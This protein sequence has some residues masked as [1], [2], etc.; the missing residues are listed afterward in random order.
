MFNIHQNYL[1]EIKS[2][3]GYIDKKYV[4]DYFNGLHPSQ[5]MHILNCKKK[6]NLR[7]KSEKVDSNMDTEE[8]ESVN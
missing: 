4:I 8:I 5:Q 2:N 1:K 7:E 3:R 6:Y